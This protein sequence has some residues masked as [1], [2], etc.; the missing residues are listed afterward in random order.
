V[1]HLAS[2]DLLLREKLAALHVQLRLRLQDV[3]GGGLQRQVVVVGEVDQVVEHRIIEQLPP[4]SSVYGRRRGRCGF[5]RVANPM[6]RDR[7][8]WTHEIRPDLAGT[9]CQ[10]GARE[11]REAALSCAGGLTGCGSERSQAAQL[12]L[13][14][15]C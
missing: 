12:I 3:H 14:R 1:L 4:R 10:E 7:G 15:D 6:C 9:K 8:G 2:Q 13:P 11:Q 5:W